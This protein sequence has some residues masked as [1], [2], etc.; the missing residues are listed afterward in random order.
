MLRITLLAHA[1]TSAQRQFRFPADEGIDAIDAAHVE[2]V[3]ASLG[4]CSMI[5][6]GPERRSEET[7]GA[8]GLD[9]TPSADLRAWSAGRWDGQAVASVAEHDPEGFQS[10]RT[11]PDAT[12]NGGES[13]RALLSRVAGWLDGQATVNG[14]ALVIADPSVI[15]AALV[16]VLAADARTFWRLD[17]SP[18]SLSVVQYAHGEWRLRSLNLDLRQAAG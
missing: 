15:R 16:H 9:A 13:L 3:R 17:V 4:A 10:W 6:C 18:L 7:A 2:R 1:P 8:L 14:R 5:W 11:D 12:P